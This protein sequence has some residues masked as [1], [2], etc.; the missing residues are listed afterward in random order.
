MKITQFRCNYCGGEVAIKSRF[1]KTAVCR[2]CNTVY[3]LENDQI[4]PEG[5]NKPFKP[6]SILKVGS[7]GKYKDKP[8]QVLGRIRL[9]DEDDVWDEWYVLIEN[10]PYWL[11][12]SADLLTLFSTQRIVSPVKDFEKIK[13][14]EVLALGENQVFIS[15]KGQ[16][17]VTGVE[18]EFSGKVKPGANYR[19]VQGTSGD[20]VFAI[21]YYGD[22]IR[23]LKG[24]NITFNDL[25]IQS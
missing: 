6:L 15:E 19:Y 20:N 7:R 16:A 12:E 2:Y 11:E 25:K 8:L 14:G 5:V 23:L 18:G 10:K 4:K 13:V 22:E 9:E 21:E 17:Q 3:F 24:V 1:A